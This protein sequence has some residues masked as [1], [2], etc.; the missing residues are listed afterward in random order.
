[1]GGRTTVGSGAGG[2]DM[3]SRSPAG[4]QTYATGKVWARVRIG[5]RLPAWDASV[6]YAYRINIPGL[7]PGRYT[8]RGFGASSPVFTAGTGRRLYSQLV[9]HALFFFR[10][11]HDGNLVDPRVLDRRPSHLTDRS[12][13]SY[14]PA[15]YSNGVLSASLKPTVRRVNALGG[16]F[17]AGD[18]IKLVQTASY[19]DAMILVADRDYRRLLDHGSANFTREARYE[20]DWLQ[21]MWDDRHRTLYYQVGIGDG[22]NRFHGDHDA[23]RLPQAD[24]RLHAAPGS[25]NLAGRLAADFALCYQVYRRSSPAYA[26]RCLRSAEHVFALAR[27]SHVGT[28][29]TASPHDYYPESSWRDDL[30]LGAAELALALQA[31]HV[32][33]GLPH[34][35][36]AFYISRAAHWARA[37]ISSSEN[38][39]DTLNLYDVSG[40]AHYELVRALRPTHNRGS[41]GATS[42]MLL[43]N[44]KMQLRAAAAESAKDPFGFG[45]AYNSQV[46]MTP[47]GLGLALESYFY[48]S[49]TR[50]RTFSNFG[51]TQLGWALGDNAW[52]S[53][54]IVGAGSTFPQCLQHEVANLSGNLNGKP[55]ILLGATV[56]GP[57]TVAS[58]S[59]LGLQQGMRA[60]PVKGGDRFAPFDARGVKYIDNVIDYPSTEPANDYTAPTVLLFA[61]LAAGAHM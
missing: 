42:R 36:P 6:P 34:A 56:D 2:P 38:G 12:A 30:E 16:W 26:G 21:R 9:A 5:R 8:I 59:G 22:N 39:T 18:F 45:V 17:D 14:Y 1:M 25:P 32:P 33:S 60:C 15:V 28:L 43:A 19:A 46:D 52:G 53:S 29:L 49:L 54:F 50:T 55:P 37:Y 40:L 13:I 23:W 10:A 31:G 4:D 27:T 47:H 57:N 35:K 51:A 58:F 20:L 24:D 7:K 61:E 11:Q 48:D 44:L 41:A 3:G